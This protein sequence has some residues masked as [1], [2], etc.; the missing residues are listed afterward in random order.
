MTK[1]LLKS[2]IGGVAIMA[3]LLSAPIWADDKLEDFERA[4]QLVAEGKI[5][6]LNTIL[7]RAEIKP[8]WRLLEVEFERDD[9]QWIYELEVLK[10]DGEVIELLYDA[11]T[12]AYLGMED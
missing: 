6:P 3:I 4:R 2:S 10:E 5:V 1:A 7:E 12:G 8:G 9:G 11:E